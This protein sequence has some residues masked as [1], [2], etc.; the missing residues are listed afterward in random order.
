MF[1]PD[2][3]WRAGREVRAN[4]GSAGIDEVQLDDVERQGVTACLPALAPDLRAGSD[5]PQPVRRV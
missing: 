3:L 4:G 5:R 1:R 2:L